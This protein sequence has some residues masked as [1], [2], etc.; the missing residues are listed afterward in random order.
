MTKEYKTRLIQLAEEIKEIQ[1]GLYLN[2]FDLMKEKV[3]H[4][5]GYILVLKEL[6]S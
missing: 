2:K 1:D 3:N 6:K 5:L 4:L